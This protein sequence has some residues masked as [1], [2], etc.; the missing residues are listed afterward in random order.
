MHAAEE[1]DDP[2]VL[3]SAARSGTHALLAVGR[4]DAPWSWVRSP[5]GGCRSES[6]PIDGN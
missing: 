6:G 5:S 4:F 3:A 2:L 1:L